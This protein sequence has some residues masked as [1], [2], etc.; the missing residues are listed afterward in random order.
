MARVLL[1]ADLHLDTPFEWAPRAAAQKR[2]QALRDT[3]DRI[4]TLAVE[5]NVDAVLCGG[6]LYEQE[7][8]APDTGVFLR[9]AFERARPIR[10]HIAP[11]NH[12]WLGPA[13]LYRRVQWSENVHVFSSDQLQPVTLAQG[14]TLWGA[15]HCK[16]AGTG[17]FLEGFRASGGGVHLA[18]F[19]G[20]EQGWLADQGAEKFPHAP[21]RAE[22]IAAAGLHHAFVG[23]YHNPRDAPLY[24]YPGNPEPLSFGEEGDRGAVI[25]EVSADG[26]V[27]RRRV[28]V[29]TAEVADLTVQLDDA[30]SLQDVRDR[31]RAALA[32]R[33]GVARVTLRGEVPPEVDVREEAVADVAPWMDAVAVR[34]AGLGAAYDLEKIRE[35]KSVRGQFVRDVLAARELEDDLRRRVLVTGLR[36]LDGRKDLEVE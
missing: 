27:A 25:A 16:P 30:A 13:S 34:T 5:E 10:V 26:S 28:H 17:N 33:R 24:T 23:H 11:G 21:F 35:E 15:A 3:L 20:S 7:R 31:V 14:V 6:D 4:I 2:R 32:G 29:A 18:L 19:H 8:F 22:E 12:D 1:F 36:A 9:D